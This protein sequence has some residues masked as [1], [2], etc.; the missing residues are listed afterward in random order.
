MYPWTTA[1]PLV[2]SSPQ[3]VGTSAAKGTAVPDRLGIRQSE[4]TMKGDRGTSSHDPPET[5][6]D[7]GEFGLIGRVTAGRTQPATTLLGPGDDAAVVA[8]ADG[9]VVASTDV[10]VEGVHFR[11]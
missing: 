1:R 4:V 6:A 11:L 7:V 5:V 2:A 9:R 8:A 3:E 10:L